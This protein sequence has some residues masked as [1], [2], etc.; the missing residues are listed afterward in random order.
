[1]SSDPRFRQE[2]RQRTQ[3]RGWQVERRDAIYAPVL[4]TSAPSVRRLFL[5]SRSAP[6]PEK[7]PRKERTGRL[8]SADR[9][10][11]VKGAPDEPGE[12]TSSR[13]GAAQ[14]TTN[15]GTKQSSSAHRVEL[16]TARAYEMLRTSASLAVPL[17]CLA[18][19]G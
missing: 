14:P 7:T 16:D 13:P 2:R 12:A 6:V 9:A 11:A 17:L 18:T 15:P 5:E 19:K 10:G 4:R 1:M 8:R 3:A